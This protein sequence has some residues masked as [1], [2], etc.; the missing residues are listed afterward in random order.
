MKHKMGSMRTEDHFTAK[1]VE[2]SC[3]AEIVSLL[4]AWFVGCFFRF[5]SLLVGFF[6]GWFVGW[7]G[8]VG[9]LG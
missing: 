6:V 7:L 8:Q 4:V 3:L 5:V 2:T 1:A 9:C